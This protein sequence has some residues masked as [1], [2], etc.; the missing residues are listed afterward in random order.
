M[1][2]DPNKLFFRR[3]AKNMLHLAAKLIY[4]INIFIERTM[5]PNRT[6]EIALH[7]VVIII[8]FSFN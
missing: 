4:K 2:G 8:S 1:F 7:A 6:V 5:L 3:L